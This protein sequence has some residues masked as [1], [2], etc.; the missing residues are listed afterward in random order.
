MCKC[1]RIPEPE[2][3]LGTT[4]KF[5]ALSLSNSFHQWTVNFRMIRLQ[6][7]GS[8]CWL[9]VVTPGWTVITSSQGHFFHYTE[10]F[11]RAI[12]YHSLDT[13]CIRSRGI[14]VI[15]FSSKPSSLVPSF[16]QNKIELVEASKTSWISFFFGSAALRKLS[17]ISELVTFS[18]R[19]I[20]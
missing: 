3:K 18:Y 6:Q 12:I 4:L 13:W 14:S 10:A 19:R 15:Y 20:F 7:T 11:Q 2:D 16:C 8:H 17:E 1:S 9:R 5:A